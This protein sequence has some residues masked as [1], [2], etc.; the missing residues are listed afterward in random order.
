[1]G[2]MFQERISQKRLLFLEQRI[3]L[4]MAQ[5]PSQN[6]TLWLHLLVIAEKSC[7]MELLAN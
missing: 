3:V 4:A 2:V 7:Y 5:Q 6:Q 1:M